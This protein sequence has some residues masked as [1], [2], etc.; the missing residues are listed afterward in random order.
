MLSRF[1]LKIGGGG[2]KYIQKINGLF[3]SEEKD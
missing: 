1:K 2:Q 3:K